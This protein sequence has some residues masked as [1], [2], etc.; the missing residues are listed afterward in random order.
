MD[1]CIF[2]FFSSEL[3]EIIVDYFILEP[4]PFK[5]LSL[6]SL[7]LFEVSEQSG[8]WVPLISLFFF[9]CLQ[10]HIRDLKNKTSNTV[11]QSFYELIAL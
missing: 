4:A 11:S 5:A 10:T 9:L 2:F 3:Q 6:L 1:E 8:R 7:L